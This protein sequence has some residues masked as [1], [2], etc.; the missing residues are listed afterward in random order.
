MTQID[1]EKA[2][3]WLDHLRDGVTNQNAEAERITLEAMK[4]P[5]RCHYCNG[6]GRREEMATSSIGETSPCGACEETGFLR[7]VH[8][9]IPHGE[10]C[11]ICG[12]NFRHAVHSRSGEVDDGR[13]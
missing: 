13:Y 4:V 6:T 7:H 5:Y 1:T 9:S 10:N 3:E 2:L 11:A 12:H 8:R